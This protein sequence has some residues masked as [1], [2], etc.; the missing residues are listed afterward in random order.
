[1]RSISPKVRP[2]WAAIFSCIL[3]EAPLRPVIISLIAERCMCRASAISAWAPC[4]H[5]PAWF[6]RFFMAW[7][8]LREGLA[9]PVLIA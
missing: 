7:T 9:R 2:K 8:S 5:T 6:K 1:M 3:V 4:H